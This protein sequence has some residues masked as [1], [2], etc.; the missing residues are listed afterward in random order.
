M[1]IIGAKG[2]AK[3]ILEILHQN[4]NIDNLVFYDDIN[5]DIGGLLYG[6]FPILK[7]L[8]EVI[9]FFKRNKNEFTIGIG[10]PLLRLAMYNK[11]KNIGGK[12][13]STISPNAD[14][15]HYGNFISEGINIASGVI[16]TND[17]TIGKGCLINWNTTIGHDSFI[18]KFVELCP[19]VNISG[20]CKIGDYSF[21]GTSATILP[22][23]SIGKNVIIGAGAVV[24]KDV[25]DN[26]VV[27]GIPG[28]VI[29]KNQPLIFK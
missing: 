3:E 26:S 25:P 7:S 23:I 27:V 9:N 16:I 17:I 19:N 15:G 13:V 11:F 28:K 24:T 4:E 2:L 29:K 12:F 20:N 8:P 5:N 6:K 18:G 21:I 22:K 10:N 14:I 1:L